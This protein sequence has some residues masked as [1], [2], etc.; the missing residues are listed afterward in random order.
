MKSWVCEKRAKP[1]CGEIELLASVASLSLSLSLSLS[2]SISLFL[3]RV[4]Q[5]KY[6]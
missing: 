4:V 1:F 3:S 5:F 6:V 2:V